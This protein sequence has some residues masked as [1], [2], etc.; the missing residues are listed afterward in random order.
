MEDYGARPRKRRRTFAGAVPI[1]AN[2]K[3]DD[4]LKGDIGIISE[5]LFKSLFGSQEDHEAG[6]LSYAAIC[7]WPTL[8][9]S[10]LEKNN[11]SILPVR[12]EE[13]HGEASS[14]RFPAGSSILQGFVRLLQAN[15]FHSRSRNVIEIL[16]LDVQPLELKT[17]FLR[18]DGEAL[19][20]HNDVQK[21]FGGGFLPSNA[22]RP[23]KGKGK[24]PPRISVNH[25]TNARID[26]D[27]S[28]ISQLKE[29]VRSSLGHVPILNCNDL[30]L[31]PLPSHPITHVAFPPA[32]VIL[33]EPVMQGLVSANTEIFVEVDHRGKLRK[34]NL[35]SPVTRS[36]NGLS[37]DRVISEE[38]GDTT[39]NFYSAAENGEDEDD[40]EAEERDIE[41]KKVDL[42]E[43]DESSSDESLS[44][45][46]SP[47]NMISLNSPILPSQASGILS[48]R[49][50]ATP[51]PFGTKATG[52]NSPGS[53]FS[54][55]TATTASQ[56]Y[57]QRRSFQVKPLV[58]RI[59]DVVLH[60]RPKADEDDEAR[61]F[62]DVK[63]LVRLGC[64]SGDWV[65]LVV[66]GSRDSD[67]GWHIDAF[68]DSEATEAFRPVKVYG[69]PDLSS[70]EMQHYPKTELARRQSQYSLMLGSRPLPSAFV[71][72][73]LFAN[74][75]E[76][77]KITLAALASQ[78]REDQ[79]FTKSKVSSSAIPPVAK[80]LTL[81]R[82]P[83]PV[84]T[85]RATSAGIFANLKYYFEYRR[86]LVQEGDLIAVTIDATMSRI[87]SDGGSL[88]E[89]DTELEELLLDADPLEG[90]DKKS[91]EIAWFKVGKISGV[92]GD[93]FLGDEDPDLWG[94]VAS[95]EP[96]TTKMFQ[97]GSMSAKLPTSLTNTWLYYL[98]ARNRPT[99]RATKP[100]SIIAQD[101]IPKAY[102]SKTQRRVRELLAAATSPQASQ[103][104][105]RPLALLLHSTQ[106]DVGKSHT[107]SAACAELGLHFYPIDSYSILTEGGGGGDVK[108]E[109][110][111]R[112]KVEFAMTC[113]DEITIP[114]IQHLEALTAERIAST[115]SDLLED[116]RALAFTTTEV[117]KIPERIRSL[118]THELEISAPDESER[119][120]ILRNLINEK[121]IELAHDVDLS[122]VA[123]K[124]AALVAGDLVEVVERACI[125]RQ[126]RLDSM[127]AKTH[128]CLVRD[129]IISGGTNARCLTKGDFDAAV[130]VARKNFA[131]SIG[132]PKIPNVT[133][134]DVG[135]LS[136]VKDAVMETIQLPLE[137][138]ELF[139]E[140]MKKRSG[141]LFYGPPGTGKTLFA[142]AIAT[143]FSLNFFSVK[144]PELL[145]MYIGE[146]EANV[147]R[148]FQKARDA[149][150]CVVFF[151]ELDS[152]APKRGNQGDS[153]GVM[154][155]IVSQLLAEL[156]GMSDGKVPSGGV[157]VIGATNR[158]DLLDQALLRP[159]RFDKMLYLGI[160]DTHDKQLTILEALTRKFISHPDLSLRRVAGRLPFTY[161][162]A[163]LY[164]L[165]SDAMLKAIIRQAAAVD[166][167]IK[168]LPGG[169]VSTAKYFDQYATK[170]DIAVM[171]TEE[172][173]SAAQREL[174]GSVR[175]VQ[176]ENILTNSN[177]ANFDLVPRSLNTTREFAKHLSLHHSMRSSPKESRQWV[178]AVRA[179]LYHQY[180]NQRHNY[181]QIIDQEA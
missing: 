161:T 122:N 64:F 41:D 126:E 178:A 60:P 107:I 138:P 167:K 23:L 119:E 32:E 46:D 145:N 150:P 129:I 137:R 96:Q 66:S 79:N 16:A 5:P 43:T 76:P 114:V 2:L 29:A 42:T 175:Y 95:A 130:D 125:A 10:A 39:D 179:S 26:Q 113:G 133:W 63:M 154:D 78:P 108:T 84:A 13:L 165:C 144:G 121:A 59:P 135:G 33:C 85:E 4:R 45:D 55:F 30:L 116:V 89:I 109:G 104:H 162:G 82:V 56:R 103:L 24:V 27:Q 110:Y 147:R 124:T 81:L 91:T 105:V 99:S 171:V 74:I 65:K 152:V 123:V 112:K 149:R 94:A 17:V 172:D 164:A 127:A 142:K 57:Q 35:S 93:D 62:V 153:G 169:P 87:L 15:P 117:E 140:G 159:G 166:T 170:E 132:A 176:A 75:G 180:L 90:K 111:L 157:F 28:Q 6:Q 53:V 50:A 3:L 54:S 156:D 83:T 58:I 128:E 151:D 120:S 69:L 25:S 14:I 174:V 70:D 31:L 158:P 7:P 101:S 92:Y 34:Q 160:A 86:R 44:D 68:G 19:R 102:I 77:S 73:I 1:R 37:V 146:S 51:R 18:V 12:C 49:T 148:V 97:S 181:G 67:H 118:F 71:S 22:Y 136:N 155:R 36:L 61:V 143:E 21:Q 11:W 40:E 168:N 9:G 20:K 88:L 98:E 134:D 177:R 139:S 47:D 38:D 163:D 52:A 80:E 106:R 115:L 100:S 8:E 141:I 131:D 48:S 72:P 173:F